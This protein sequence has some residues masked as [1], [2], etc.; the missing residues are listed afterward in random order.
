MKYVSDIYSH[1]FSLVSELISKSVYLPCNQFA[2]A[3]P[4]QHNVK[5][6]VSVYYVKLMKLRIHPSCNAYWTDAV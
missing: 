2:M 1:D 6:K 3:Q 4:N 5:A